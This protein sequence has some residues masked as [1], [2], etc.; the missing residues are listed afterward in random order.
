MNGRPGFVMPQDIHG[1]WMNTL[2]P[3]ATLS[4]AT[5]AVA[6]GFY[7]P[8]DIVDILEK[9]IILRISATVD[10]YLNFTLEGPP[11]ADSGDILFLAGTEDRQLPV[12]MNHISGVT[13][14]GGAGILSVTVLT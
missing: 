13:E 12:G 6:N 3:G 8:G 10:P 9:S 4:V 2:A 14:G 11:A 7:I 1:R 5:S